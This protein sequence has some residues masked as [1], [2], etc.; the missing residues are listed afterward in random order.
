MGA[1][2]RMITA[3]SQSSI[4]GELMTA[5]DGQFSDTLLCFLLYSLRQTAVMQEMATVWQEVDHPSGA[6]LE[7]CFDVQVCL[8]V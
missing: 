4:N 2:C 5:D 1:L 8:A 7:E 3:R 6:T